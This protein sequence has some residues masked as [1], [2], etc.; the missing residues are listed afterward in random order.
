MSP[1]PEREPAGAH[2]QDQSP[3]ETSFAAYESARKRFFERLRVDSEIR[4]LEKAWLLP[5]VTP[6]LADALTTRGPAPC[7]AR[8][9]RGGPR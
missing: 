7:Q 9:R 4:R 6:R 3:L 5:V 8:A 2:A 1:P